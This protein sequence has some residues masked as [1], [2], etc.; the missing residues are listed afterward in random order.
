V[1]V[2]EP[3]PPGHDAGREPPRRETPW[4]H[5]PRPQ[6]PSLR[7]DDRP[8]LSTRNKVIAGAFV[9][10]LYAGGMS[11]RGDVLP[12][13]VGGILA[14]ILLVLVLNRIEER[15]RRR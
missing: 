10:I 2:G 3:P 15:R 8:G 11:A 9:G 12:G 5:E 6:P 7:G 4:D 14:G 1:G 13:V